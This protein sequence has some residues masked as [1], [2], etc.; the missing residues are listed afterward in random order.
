MV[1]EGKVEE[2]V[3]MVK[4]QPKGK[5]FDFELNTQEGRYFLV[6]AT[7]SLFFTKSQYVSY[8]MLKY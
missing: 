1:A 7:I 4:S 8:K 6:S 5:P 2:I 3:Q